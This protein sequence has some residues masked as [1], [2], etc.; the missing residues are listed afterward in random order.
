MELSL[1]ALVLPAAKSAMVLAWRL[2]TGQGQALSA[3]SQK[4]MGQSHLHFHSALP[5]GKSDVL[6]TCSLKKSVST[7]LDYLDFG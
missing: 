1:E 4:K 2:A 5:K 7:H 3:F 6:E